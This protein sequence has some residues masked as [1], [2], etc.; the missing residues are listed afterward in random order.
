MFKAILQWLIDTFL[1]PSSVKVE[2]ERPLAR[3]VEGTRRWDGPV[4]TGGGTKLRPAERRNGQQ[5]AKVRS[6]SPSAN[7]RVAVRPNHRPYWVLR[8][9]RRVGNKLVGAYRTRLGSFAGE[10][11]LGH[12]GRAM[13]FIINPPGEVRTGPHGACFRR[14]HGE[15]FWIHFN[16]GYG[17]DGGILAVE[18]IIAD[19]LKR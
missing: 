14:R 9:W 6:V 16:R 3:R 7:G 11:E 5:R 18:A 10:I 13:F 19:A 1:R 17:V 12:S 15:R 4:A 8:G 2:D